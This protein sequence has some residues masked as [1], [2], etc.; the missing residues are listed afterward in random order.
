[1]DLHIPF[2]ILVHTFSE[3]SPHSVELDGPT[4]NIQRKKKEKHKSLN[5]SF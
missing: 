1:M 2:I 4:Q 3:W 5:I